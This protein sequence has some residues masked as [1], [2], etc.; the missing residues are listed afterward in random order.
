MHS[1][2]SPHTRVTWKL[3]AKVSATSWP[4]FIRSFPLVVYP[5][6]EAAPSRVPARAADQVN[7]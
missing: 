1:V 5:L 6:K 2:Q 7:V 4:I 3:V